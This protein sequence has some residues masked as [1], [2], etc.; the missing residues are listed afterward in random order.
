ML[1]FD[2]TCSGAFRSVDET[3]GDLATGLL[4][5]FADAL[6]EEVRRSIAE[7]MRSI[8]DPECEALLRQ[9]TDALDE[10]VPALGLSALE[11]AQIRRLRTVA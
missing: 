11:A 4:D 8:A 10:D 3:I 5:V 1:P 7:T 2:V 6:M 9:A